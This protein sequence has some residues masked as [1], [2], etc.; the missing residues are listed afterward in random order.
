MHTRTSH[1]LLVHWHWCPLTP[2]QE[3]ELARL[4]KRLASVSR[5]PS[6]RRIGE[7]NAV[8]VSAA[9]R[10]NTGRRHSDLSVNALVRMGM[11]VQEGGAASA[12]LAGP[13]AGA[14]MVSPLLPPLT[15]LGEV[16]T[17]V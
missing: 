12:G 15:R 11:W 13:G 16:G 5:D 9:A 7:L 17:P 3:L 1:V 10:G 14:G 6:F 4:K 2:S 8:L